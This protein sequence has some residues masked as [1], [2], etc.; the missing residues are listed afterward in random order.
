MTRQQAK[1]VNGK[2]NAKAKGQTGTIQR[3]VKRKEVPS[4]ITLT[5]LASVGTVASGGTRRLSAGS[6]KKDQE[7]NFQSQR[8]KR[9]RR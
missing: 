1:G 4:Q 9:L 2:G 8:F 3:M 5:L 6:R 7:A